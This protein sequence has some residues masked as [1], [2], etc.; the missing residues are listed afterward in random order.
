M[1]DISKRTGFLYHN[2]MIQSKPP[3]VFLWAFLYKL[4][5][6][7]RRKYSWD[8]EKNVPN[9]RGHVS[10]KLVFL[11]ITYIISLKKVLQAL[12]WFRIWQATEY[13]CLFFIKLS[14]TSPSP[15][16]KAEKNLHYKICKI[17]FMNKICYKITKHL[18]NGESVREDW[19]SSLLAKEFCFAIKLWFCLHSPGLTSIRMLSCPYTWMFHCPEKGRF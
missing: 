11:I 14:D 3:T 6:L 15:T 17:Y 16:T 5:N 13:S 8:L 7:L 12:V 19:Q 10:V 4:K 18:V 9:R 1:K 2:Q